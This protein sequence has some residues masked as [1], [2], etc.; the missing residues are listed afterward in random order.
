MIESLSCCMPAAVL[1][2]RRPTGFD[3]KLHRRNNKQILSLF[4]VLAAVLRPRPL[5]LQTQSPGTVGSRGYGWFTPI[6]PSLQRC[7]IGWVRLS[8]VTLSWAPDAAGLPIQKQ[9]LEFFQRTGAIQ[10][11]YWHRR[12]AR[13]ARKC[14]VLQPSNS[15]GARLGRNDRHRCLPKDHVERLR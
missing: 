14:S 15:E 7:S 2:H 9:H 13:L 8:W 5:R 12:P 11:H 6:M 10:R 4:C 1:L 3:W